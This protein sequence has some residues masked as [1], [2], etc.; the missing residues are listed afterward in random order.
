MIKTIKC[1]CR[2][3]ATNK[4]R[5]SFVRL[6]KAMGTFEELDELKWNETGGETSKL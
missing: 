6:G 2:G 5:T 4:I 1:Y 3:D